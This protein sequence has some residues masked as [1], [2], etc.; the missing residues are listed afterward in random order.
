MQLLTELTCSLSQTD[1]PSVIVSPLRLGRVT[2][3]QKLENGTIG[4]VVSDFFRRLETRTLT[5]RFAENAKEATTPFQCVFETRAGCEYV[6]HV[7]QGV[8]DLDENA[9]VTSVDEVDAYDLFSR[10]STL[11]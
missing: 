1:V 7:L 3:L 5:Q 10:N 11:A 8:S 9:T 6:I 2:V 4:I